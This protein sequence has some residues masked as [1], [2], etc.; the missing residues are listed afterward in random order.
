LGRK[1]TIFAIPDD[2]KLKTRL[3]DQESAK[4]GLQNADYESGRVKT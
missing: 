4:S 2:L 1:T 3:I